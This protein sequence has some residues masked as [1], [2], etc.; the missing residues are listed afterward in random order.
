MRQLSLTSRCPP[1]FRAKAFLWRKNRP[2]AR[3]LDK[4][5]R[6][7]YN[8]VMEILISNKQNDLTIDENNVEKVVQAVLSLEETS[9]DEISIN[10]VDT[11]EICKLHDDF[12][13]DPSPTDCI[14]FPIDTEECHYRVLG[15]VFVCPRTAIDYSA[16]HGGES[17]K[18]MYLYLVHGMLHL[19]GYND[20]DPN[21][22]NEMRKAEDRHMKNLQKLN[23]LK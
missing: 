18:E 11:A 22:Q 19:L 13:N 21:D 17:S 15:E 3:S 10:F 16:E 20:I 2:P 9:C 23:L 4:K 14:S 1:Y 7:Q 8:A 6:I 5:E 12:F